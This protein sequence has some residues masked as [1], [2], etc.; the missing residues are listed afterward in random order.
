MVGISGTGNN[1]YLSF[2]PFATPVRLNFSLLVR[3]GGVF[4]FH[5]AVW[6]WYCTNTVRLLVALA[7]LVTGCDLPII[8][9]VTISTARYRQYAVCLASTTAGWARWKVKRKKKKKKKEKAF[10]FSPDQTIS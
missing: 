6:Y 2:L 4:F 10:H 8:L 5:R 1:F 3:W 9:Q 7:F